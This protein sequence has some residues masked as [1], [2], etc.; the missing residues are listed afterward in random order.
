MTK[1][2]DL[3]NLM[4]EH[5]EIMPEVAQCNGLDWRL[6][7]RAGYRKAKNDLSL[8]AIRYEGY[9]KELEKMLTAAGV[10]ESILAQIQKEFLL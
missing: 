2:G 1:L 10:H 3:H 6:G 9:T 4:M 5:P 8:V 7:Y